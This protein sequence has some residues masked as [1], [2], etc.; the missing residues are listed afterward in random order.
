M[1]IRKLEIDF[2]K[3]I[4]RINGEEFTDKPVIVALPGPDDWP[5]AML[6]NPEKATDPKE[7]VFLSVSYKD[8][9]VAGGGGER[10]DKI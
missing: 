2:D 5:L 4:L 10:G 7:H 6:I 9:K 8:V 3:Q 1:E